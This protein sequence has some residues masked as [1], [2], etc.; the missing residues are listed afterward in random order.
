MGPRPAVTTVG[1]VTGA[2]SGIGEASARRLEGTVDV[3]LLADLNGVPPLDITDASALDELA[4]RIKD[5][6]S[7][8]SIV[9]AAGISPTMA[10]W[11]RVLEVDLVATA[12]LLEVL[13]PLAT[14]GTAIVC[15]S[16]MA[17]HIMARLASA[18]PEID[19]VIDDPMTDGFYDAFFAAVGDDPG[20]A[21]AYAKRGV[22]RLVT[23]EAIA[24]GPLGARINS[25]SPGSID[26]PMGRQEFDQQPFMKVIADATPLR[27]MGTPD[28]LAAVAAFLLSDDASFVTGT[29]VLVDGGATGA[30]TQTLQ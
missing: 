7:L 25:I 11:R 10:D 18:N 2:S 15:V 29:D 5:A 30:V 3:L 16:S 20:A 24:L 4:Q 28:E 6:G 1:L 22:Q 26:T 23:R 14:A 21:Y 27:R 12:R 19:A 13:R 8:R 9:H 17:A